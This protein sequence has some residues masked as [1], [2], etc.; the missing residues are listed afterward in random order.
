MTEDEKVWLRG[1]LES[2]DKDA[3][4]VYGSVIRKRRTTANAEASR[5][6]G[7]KGGRPPGSKDSKPRTRTLKRDRPE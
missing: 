1:L 5:E 6:N 2:G 3:W 4:G 7:K